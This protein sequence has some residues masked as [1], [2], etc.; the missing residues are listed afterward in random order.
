MQGLGFIG[1]FL[2]WLKMDKRKRIANDPVFYVFI[3]NPCF[4]KDRHFVWGKKTKNVSGQW[5]LYFGHGNVLKGY[6]KVMEKSLKVRSEKEWIN[7]GY[8]NQCQSAKKLPKEDL[9]CLFH[10]C[11]CVCLSSC[12]SLSWA[13][14]LKAE[15]M[16][17]PLNCLLNR[18]LQS[19]EATSAKSAAPY[20]YWSPALAVLWLQDKMNNT[21]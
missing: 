14:G 8:L 19:F 5:S 2:I 6:G 1:F 18:P 15:P 4:L 12:L 13:S 7:P 20:I 9:C 17:P 11:T 21:V 3:Q 16:V 10:M